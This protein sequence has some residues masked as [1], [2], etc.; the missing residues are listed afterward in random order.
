MRP[1]V[2]LAEGIGPSLL[3][4]QRNDHI[5]SLLLPHHARDVALTGEILSQEHIPRADALN[6]PVSYLDLG[7]ASQRNRILPSRSAVPVQDVAGR[8]HTKRDALHVL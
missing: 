7:F 6:C 5:K 3:C 8:R 4:S 1:P 2:L